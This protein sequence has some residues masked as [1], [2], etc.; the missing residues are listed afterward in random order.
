[1]NKEINNKQPSN[2]KIIIGI[3]A[4]LLV[5]LG[6]FSGALYSEKN[7]NEQI[8][9]KEKQQVLADLNALTLQYDEV[10]ADNKIVND[11]L[12]DARERIDNLVDS[13]T[14]SQSSVKDLIGYKNLYIKLKKEKELLFEENERLRIENT[15]LTASLDS[16]SIQLYETKLFSDALLDQNKTLKDVVKNASYLQVLGLDAVGVIERSSGK[17][18][19]TERARRSDKL[20]VCFMIA[21]NDLVESGDMELYVQVIDPKNNV[22]GLNNELV[23]NEDV[24][25]YS[26]ISSFNYENNNLDICEYIS[27]DEKFETGNYTVNIF[28]KNTL[29][30]STSLTLK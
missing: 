19:P 26:L 20:K 7:E 6:I 3:L 2:Q 25:N 27:S 13:L 5:G 24:L 8:L 14:N 21:K 30:S 18:I 15:S 12:I 22:L 29:L 4:I 23:F 9:T 1:M 11:D 10:I 28:N 17:L 16:T